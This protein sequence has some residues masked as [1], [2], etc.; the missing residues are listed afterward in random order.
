MRSKREILFGFVRGGAAIFVA[1]AV[2]IIFIFICSDTPGKAIEYLLVK[3]ILNTG[4]NGISFNASSF[5]IVLSRMIPTIFTGLAVC[6]MFSANQFNLAGEGAVML[7]GFVA[8]L[9][10][11]YWTMPAG[12]HVTVCVL[13][14]ALSCGVVMLLPALL[15]T[16]LG[17]SEMVSSLMLNYVIQYVV[18]HFLNNDFADRS[19]GSTQTFPFAETAKVPDLVPGTDLTWGFVVALVVTVLVA[20][21]MYRT[22]WGYAIR[23]IGINKDFSKY[24][25]IKVGAIIV[26]SQVVGGFISG[27]S[28]SIEVLGRF[29]TFLWRELPGYGWTGVTIAILAKNNPA[30]VPIAAFFMAYLERGCELMRTFAGVPSEMLDIIQA[31]IFLFFAAEQFLAGYRQKI[32]VKS[33]KE[34]LARQS[35]GA[36]QE[37]GAKA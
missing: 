17:A 32:V 19:K 10:G 18:L 13:M 21:F 15:K 14:G 8:A 24:S 16:K 35:A 5:Y 4:V 31:V 11:I 37:K 34:E 30:Y 33:A 9:C 12:V 1:L 2:A 22:R 28:G 6:V 27:M 25:G 3:P 26:L 23:M 29:D 7:G 20:I 36:A